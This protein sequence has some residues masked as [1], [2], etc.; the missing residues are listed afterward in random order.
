METN[1]LKQE[2]LSAISVE[3]DQWLK[4]SSQIKDGY[5]FEDRFLSHMRVINNILFQKSVGKVPRGVNG[6]KN[7]IA[8][9]AK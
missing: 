4:E 6:K 7:F 9:L 5:E 1:Q 3:L 2:M 8:V